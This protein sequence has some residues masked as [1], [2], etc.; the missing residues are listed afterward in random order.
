M[1]KKEKIFSRLKSD[2]MFLEDREY[3]VVGVFLQG[4]Q[5]YYLDYE[6]SDIDTKAIILPNF[7]DFV[8]NKKPVSTTHEFENKE[9]LDIKDIRL[10]F[11]C[12]KKQNINFL[13]I[14]FTDYFILNPTYEDLFKPLMD[15]AELIAH[16]NNYAGINCIAGMVFEK[17]KA[18]THRYEG[19]AETIDKYGFDPKQLH[20]ILRCRE[21]LERFCR[22]VPYKECL[23][24]T[25]PKYLIEVKKNPLLYS[26]DVVLE[27]AD[28]AVEETKEIKEAYMNTHGV[29][30]SE[31]VENLLN[32]T[33][34]EILKRK[35]KL[36][37]GEEKC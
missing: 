7:N 34:C 32:S 5:N 18:L 25:N 9:H 35:F 14:L 2:Y 6:G 33:L 29:F 17:R 26:L 27:I 28:K 11:D 23:I 8:L 20:H 15:N 21:F 24:P 13:E 22:N 1:N 31:E 30:V 36:E 4:S 16:Y 12:F 10:M 37:I 3:T 19:L